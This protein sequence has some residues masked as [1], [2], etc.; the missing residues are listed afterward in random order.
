MV[1]RCAWKKAA[2]VLVLVGTEGF[3]RADIF[4]T[5]FD[6]NGDGV[7]LRTNGSGTTSVFSTGYTNPQG[8]AFNSQSILFVADAN[9]ISTIDIDGVASSFASLT[10]PFSEA[11]IAI[12]TNDN[13]YITNY[14]DGD[15]GFVIQKYSSA[16][17]L[18]SSWEA[19]E[20]PSSMIYN[21]ADGGALY[22]TN[23]I[24]NSVGYY[25]VDGVYAEFVDLDA[26]E[27]GYQPVG[28]ALDGD[29]NLYVSGGLDLD[30]II[31]ITPLGAISS[32]VNT[33]LTG[34]A[35]LEWNGMA[36]VIADE[37]CGCGPNNTLKLSDGLGGVTLISDLGEE[38]IP[39]DVAIGTPVPEPA[40]W[41]L[42]PV[43]V[44]AMAAL[45]LRRKA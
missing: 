5:A 34:V 39:I 36:L 13:I 18:L 38:T 24:D 1:S 21:P 29:G 41:I 9:G 12:D 42:F 15:P 43:G 2:L 30:E 4:T 32:Y 40:T 28:I 6:L 7:V 37:A 17:I 33:G 31:K 3:A 45:R 35:G 11:G 19:F 10:P 16:G 27:L 22:V 25:D 26:Y 44:L 14:D 8:I 23:L 20:G